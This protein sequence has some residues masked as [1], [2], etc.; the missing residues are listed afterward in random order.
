[1]SSSAPGTLLRRALLSAALASA[2]A[3][4][5]AVAL[6]C[7][8]G[9]AAPAVPN[10]VARMAGGPV[11]SGREDWSRHTAAGVALNFA[12]CLAWAA[13]AETWA[14]A[15]PYRSPGTALAR[16]AAVAG[17]AY[18]IDQHLLPAR[19]RPAY[20]AVLPVQARVIVYA[21][22]ALAL[23]MRSALAQLNRRHELGIRRRLG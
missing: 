4:G 5:V 2:S 12:G 6:G 23:P 19:R 17:L 18:V 10:S 3:T 13:V 9:H 20:D 14:R 21:S 11:R 8:R 1:M 7:R 16:G 15:R 22:L